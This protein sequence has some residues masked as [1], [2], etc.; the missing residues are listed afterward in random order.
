MLKISRRT[1]VQINYRDLLRNGLKKT[2]SELNKIS[3]HEI[4]HFKKHYTVRLYSKKNALKGIQSKKNL[5]V[6]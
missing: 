6:T 4:R 2:I 1:E 3:F 5:K